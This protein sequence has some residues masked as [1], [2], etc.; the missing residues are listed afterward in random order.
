MPDIDYD[1]KGQFLIDAQV[2]HGSSGSPVFTSWDNRYSLIG[3][4]SQ[5][6]FID[7]K[8]QA[9]DTENYISNNKTGE[10]IGLGIVIKRRH[11]IELVECAT[12]YFIR[13]IDRS[14]LVKSKSSSDIEI[15]D[16]FVNSHDMKY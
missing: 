4:L 16:N 1:G 2:F 8:I 6:M 9:M 13:S 12:A 5:A 3:V 7:S 15:I 11:L 10:S 14:E